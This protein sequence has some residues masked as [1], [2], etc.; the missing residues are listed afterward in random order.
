MRER[1]IRLTVV[2]LALASFTLTFLANTAIAQGGNSLTAQAFAT[3]QG[4]HITG[5]RANVWT[6][7][8]PGGWYAIASPV[9]VCTT[10]QDCNG[11]FVE[12]GFVKG[13]ITSG[14][15]TGPNILQQFVAWRKPGQWGTV[16]LGTPL[17]DNTWYEF[18]V[19][20]CY[21]DWWCAFIFQDFVYI[22]YDMGFTHGLSAIC[23]GEGGGGGVPMSVFC[24]NPQWRDT[25]ANGLNW[26]LYNYN[27]TQN[28][29]HVP[30][31]RYCVT[32]V[33]EYGSWS[34]KCQ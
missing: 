24:H 19:Q 21:G 16:F 8:Q 22:F 10:N 25:P 27:W 26:W 33:Y 34:W 6:G 23:G 1:L 12:T 31:H 30:P 3:F 7:T 5:S 28:W 20:L 14:T 18:R 9:A 11:Y 29:S 2:P 13:T 32:R 4:T 17:N 15:P